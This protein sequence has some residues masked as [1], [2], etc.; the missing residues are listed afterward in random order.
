MQ[1][2]RATWKT[3]PGWQ[4]REL[5]WAASA[6]TRGMDR[7]EAAL[8]LW[9][10]REHQRH[11][12]RTAAGQAGGFALGGVLLALV[13]SYVDPATDLAFFRTY[14]LTGAPT[15]LLLHLGMAIYRRPRLRRTEQLN[16]AM[17]AGHEF[18]GPPDPDEAER[19]LNLIRKEGW[20][21]GMRAER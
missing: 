15:M 3:L 5:F 20:L 2:Y 12:L 8:L 19:L 13:I 16:A 1:D 17:L 6:G 9:Y 4:R 11:W 10:A 7:R 21:R 18:T 14:T